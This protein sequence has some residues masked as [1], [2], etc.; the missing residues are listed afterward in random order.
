MFYSQ[1]TSTIISGQ[2]L[3]TA[4]LDKPHWTESK[5]ATW[6]LRTAILGKPHWTESKNATWPSRTATLGKPHWNKSWNYVFFAS[7]VSKFWL[8]NHWFGCWFTVDKSSSV[9]VNPPAKLTWKKE[10]R[11]R[12]KWGKKTITVRQLTF[13]IQTQDCSSGK[14]NNPK[15]LVLT[16]LTRTPADCHAVRTAIHALKRVSF[17]PTVWRIPCLKIWIHSVLNISCDFK[18]GSW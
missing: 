2:I 15:P 3:G 10:M 14:V 17:Q 8:I 5:D 13:R 12:R 9:T 18:L 16:H 11:T 4:V 1:S 7:S 6:P